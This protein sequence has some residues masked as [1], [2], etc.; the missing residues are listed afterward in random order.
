MGLQD[1][2]YS[3]GYGSCVTVLSPHVTVSH[4]TGSPLPNATCVQCP[5]AYFQ[6]TE[7]RRSRGGGRDGRPTRKDASPAAALSPWRC[8]P[9]LPGF[10]LDNKVSDMIIL[11]DASRVVGAK[12]S[13]PARAPART[14]N[15]AP[16]SVCLQRWE[17]RSSFQRS[18][19][20]QSAWPIFPR[21]ITLLTQTDTQRYLQDLR[22]EVQ[23]R[24]RSL[25]ESNLG[26]ESRTP[27]QL[28]SHRTP[29]VSSPLAAR[30]AT[31]QNAL[32]PTS[33]SD[34][35]NR[36]GALMANGHVPGI[37]P[38]VSPDVV[39]DWGNST[40]VSQPLTDENFHAQQSELSSRPG[41]DR[42]GNSAMAST[43][44]DEQVSSPPGVWSIPFIM[45]AKTMKNTRK[46][47]RTW[48]ETT[49]SSQYSPSSR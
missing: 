47:K 49:P 35:I 7:V 26:V 10:L 40:V 22:E 2:S 27:T 23:H 43:Y 17:A 5:P 21:N 25:T 30:Q 39:G 31:E 42:R 29:A 12:S 41:Q 11:Q 48:G 14:V 6:W 19:S 18:V 4:P 16:S 13:A 44:P 45:P 33:F 15:D 46:N 24:R 28:S 9:T 8:Y 38:G 32:S 3:S 20:P 37:A 1:H 34:P 36:K